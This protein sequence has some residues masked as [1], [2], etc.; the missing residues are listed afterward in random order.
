MSNGL[1]AFVNSI[2]QMILELSPRIIVIDS[3]RGLK[4]LSDSQGDYRRML[5]ELAGTLSAFDATVFLVG[6]YTEEDYREL[7]EFAI[8]DGII[9]FSR[10]TET[11]RTSVSC[12]Y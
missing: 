2:E 5:F 12:V 7:P 8:A 11:T 9:Q 10:N 3:S 1:D 4:E 6:E